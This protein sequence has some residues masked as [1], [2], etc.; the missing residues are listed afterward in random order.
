MFEII[1]E[2]KLKKKKSNEYCLLNPRVC[3]CARAREHVCVFWVLSWMKGKKNLCQKSGNRVH[4]LHEK[5]NPI[6]N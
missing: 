2:Y 3:V 6:R 5:E 4:L 1:L